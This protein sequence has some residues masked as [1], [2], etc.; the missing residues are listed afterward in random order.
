MTR[1]VSLLLTGLLTGC[2]AVKS[3]VHLTKAEQALQLAREAEAPV[4]A[5]YAWTAAEELVLPE[6]DGFSISPALQQQLSEKGVKVILCK[7][8]HSAGRLRR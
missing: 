2:T 3:T 7:P 5:P 6:I 8:G 1:R 4:N